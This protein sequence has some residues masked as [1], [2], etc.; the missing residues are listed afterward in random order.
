[1]ITHRRPRA[2]LIRQRSERRLYSRSS[3]AADAR[4]YRYGR[5]RIRAARGTRDDPRPTCR[6]PESEGTKNPDKTASVRDSQ[7]LGAILSS[8]TGDESGTVAASFLRAP[9]VQQAVP[10]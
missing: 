7:G 5:H 4:D 9:A 10:L 3:A 6:R 8:A 2:R 1:M